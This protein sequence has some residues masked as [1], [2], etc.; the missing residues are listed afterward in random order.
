M[1]FV[2]IDQIDWLVHWGGIQNSAGGLDGKLSKCSLGE[3]VFY[4]RENF[5]PLGGHIAVSS[6]ERLRWKSGGN[7]SKRHKQVL[8]LAVEGSADWN[9]IAAVVKQADV[10][11]R[12]VVKSARFTANWARQQFAKMAQQK[13]PTP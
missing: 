2:I 4:V 10:N 12:P 6:G 11:E 9:S 13:G 1:T 3:C 7:V 5:Q 8:E